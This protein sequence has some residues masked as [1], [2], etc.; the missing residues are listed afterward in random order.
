MEI[1]RLTSADYEK[2]YRLWLSCPGMSL[3]NL[4]D[5]RE[6]FERFLKRNPETCFAAFED[7]LIGVLLA[8]SDG[9]RGYIYH[10]AV[11]EDY[12]HRGVGT[13]LV[14]AALQALKAR[15]VTK[16]GLL[17]FRSNADGNRFW[18]KQGFA[19]REELTYRSHELRKSIPART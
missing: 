10:A 5:S 17:V 6:G 1:R 12:R 8:G 13:A 19:A 11:A 14:D 2:V 4:D 3:N 9:R 18:E 15:Q 7:T 16:V